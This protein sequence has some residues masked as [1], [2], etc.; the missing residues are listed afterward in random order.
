MAYNILV[1]DDSETVRAVIAKAIEMSGTA[2]KSLFTA[3]NGQEALEILDR[4]WVDLV[5][6]DIN[7]PVMGGMELVKRMKEGADTKS[8]PVVIVSTEGSATRIKTLMDSGIAA[9]IRKPFTPEGLK[10]TIDGIMG[11]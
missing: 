7:M 6:A 11:K 10:S 5:F 4:E 1:V 8:I 2:V 3:G 9:F